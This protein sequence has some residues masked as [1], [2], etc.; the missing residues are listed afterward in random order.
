MEAAIDT[1][2]LR[3][4]R[5][6]H[7]VRAGVPAAWEI[8]YEEL[9][10]RVFRFLCRITGESD[11]AADLTHDTFVK[12]AEKGHQYTGRGSL[13]GWVFTIARN[14]ATERLRRDSDRHAKIHAE[15]RSE[16]STA[17]EMPPDVELRVVL[18]HALSGLSSEMRTVLLLYDVDG[19]THP[20][21]AEMLNIPVGTS[22]ARLSRARAQLRGV[23]EN[24]L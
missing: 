18:E 8:L 16:A 15:L 12:V 10:E 22:K 17:A 4:Y 9:S 14:L 21:I 13:H 5:L 6:A 7:D 1:L 20:Q 11:L 19:C 24:A 2:E 3:E 23:L